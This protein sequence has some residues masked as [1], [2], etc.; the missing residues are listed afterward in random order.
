MSESRMR[1]ATVCAATRLSS[2]TNFSN[3]ILVAVHSSINVT[4]GSI[5]STGAVTVIKP[6]EAIILLQG[7]IHKERMR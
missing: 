6:L 1:S 7:F 3:N 2:V 4:S 5:W